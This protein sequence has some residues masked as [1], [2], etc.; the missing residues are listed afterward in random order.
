[1]RS[2]IK[3]DFDLGNLVITAN[4]NTVLDSTDIQI[5][6]GRHITCDWGELC[7]EDWKLNDSAVIYNNDRLFSAYVDSN[8]R[9]F[10][11]ITE[12]DRSCTTL[13][14]PEDY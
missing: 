10:W 1:M 5:A 11:I 9:K 2:F 7:D 8:D 12:A 4:A 6:L 13:M 14:L 3:Q